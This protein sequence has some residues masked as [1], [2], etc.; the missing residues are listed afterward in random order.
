VLNVYDF[1]HES[2]CAFKARMKNE[3]LSA[4][5]LLRDKVAGMPMYR[6]KLLYQLLYLTALKL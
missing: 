2:S 3:R 6:V 4:D 1:S 5:F